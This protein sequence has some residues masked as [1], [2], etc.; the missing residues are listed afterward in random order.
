MKVN[1]GAPEGGG[2][3]RTGTPTVHMEGQ[4]SSA[5]ESCA[6]KQVKVA[7][8]LTCVMPT[9]DDLSRL[10]IVGVIHADTESVQKARQTVAEVRPD[11]VAVELDRDRYQQ[12]QNPPSTQ[13][14]ADA[15]SQT[16][17]A[18][19]DFVHQIALLESRIGDHTGAPAGTEMLAAIE[20]GRKVSAKIA[21]IDRPIQ[22]TL[23]A[24]MQVP[25]DEMYRFLGIIPA[26]SDEIQGDG[27]TTIM[28][29][30]KDDKAVEEIMN[31]FRHEFPGIARALIE[32]RDEYVARALIRILDD[33]PGKV[34]VV[35]GMGHI[36]GVRRTLEQLVN[37]S[38]PGPN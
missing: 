21:L 11:V 25:L 20:E 13:D 35:L 30:L 19:Q 15:A 31:E 36:D 6:P 14:I 22:H 16:G 34:V 37:G 4:T 24:L 9:R 12:I 7:A 33:V 32:Q 1:R 29:M 17:D 26:A 18:A 28:D 2:L 3:Q 5:R 10:I 8:G 23:N 27:V 38:G